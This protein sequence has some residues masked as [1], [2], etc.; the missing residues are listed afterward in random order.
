MPNEHEPQ[1]EP[2]VW[3]GDALT[4][5]AAERERWSALTSGYPGDHRD[6]ARTFNAI[7]R[8][9]ESVGAPPPAAYSREDTDTEA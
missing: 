4:R 2:R 8:Q 6:E 1:P 9:R 7:K 5:G 3:D